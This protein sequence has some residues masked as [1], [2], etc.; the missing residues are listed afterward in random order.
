MSEP[1]VA[2]EL[3]TLLLP[4]LPVPPL[5]SLVAPVVSVSGELLTAVG[6]P[7]TVQVITAP[8][9]TVAAVG[10]VGLHTGVKPAGKPVIA[11]V[12]PILAASVA[13]GAVLVQVKVPVYGAPTAAVVG[14]PAKDGTMSEAVTTTVAVAVEQVPGGF[15]RVGG[16]VQMVY[17]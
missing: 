14:M 3:V 12:A 11:Q 4:V 9:A 15:G 16:M 17:G 2:M 10:T 1:V 8:I 6:M 5:P 7:V 13:P